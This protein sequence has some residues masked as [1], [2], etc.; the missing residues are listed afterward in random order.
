MVLAKRKEVPLQKAWL[1]VPLSSEVIAGNAA[2]IITASRAEIKAV[3]FNIEK[4]IQKRPDLPANT[5]FFL[6]VGGVM[7]FSSAPL[8][9]LGSST[10]DI[11]RVE[12]SI[13]ESLSI[14]S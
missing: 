4:A 12:K 7:I 5:F 10:V 2:A 11:S 1:L 9:G 8:G 13:E 6:G 14:K 3:R